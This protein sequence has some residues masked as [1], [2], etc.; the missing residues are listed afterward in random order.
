[1]EPAEFIWKL[2]GWAC[3]LGSVNYS[4][5][6]MFNKVRTIINYK[7]VFSIFLKKLIA[8]YSS[9]LG[10]TRNPCSLSWMASGGLVF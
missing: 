10:L 8:S 2:F 5:P 3:L 7:S 1:V 4:I 9:T 6:E